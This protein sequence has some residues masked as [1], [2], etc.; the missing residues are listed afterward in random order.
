A[1]LNQAVQATRGSGKNIKSKFRNFKE[2]FDWS[3]EIE[4]IF[5]Q[6]NNKKSSKKISLAEIN[7][8]A[9]EYIEKKGG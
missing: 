4:N 6:K 9:N 5:T 2:F 1:W 7:A 3:N 8:L